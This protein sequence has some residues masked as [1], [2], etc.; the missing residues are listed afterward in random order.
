MTTRCLQTCNFSAGQLRK[1][2][3]KERKK[4]DSNIKNESGKERKTEKKGGRKREGRTRE[5]GERD[6][7]REG[8]RGIEREMQ[9]TWFI[10]KAFFHYRKETIS[11]HCKI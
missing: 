3:K 2:G 9:K 1:K 11:I 8:E 6:E 7:E 10:K 4:R 5:S